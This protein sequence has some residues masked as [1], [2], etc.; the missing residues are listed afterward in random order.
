M[1]RPCPDNASIHEA[2]DDI[3]GR[4]RRTVDVLAP[5]LDP[6]LLDRE[7]TLHALAQLARI[8]RFTRI[9]V[10]FHDCSKAVR[11]GH[12]LIHLARRFPSYI[13]LRRASRDH[14]EE[15]GSWIAVDGTHLLW[16]P[17][18]TISTGAYAFIDEAA[19]ARKVLRPFDQWWQ[20]SEADPA[21]RE[22]HL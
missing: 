10:L 5:D 9:R 4:A 17:D 12:R 6:L 21:L 7:E 20:H 14:Q 3:L 13:Q 11:H 1:Q 8:S 15:A 22:L 2:C 19:Q 16:R 18:Y